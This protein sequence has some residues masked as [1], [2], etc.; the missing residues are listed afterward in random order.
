MSIFRQQHLLPGPPADDGDVIDLRHHGRALLRFRYGILGIGLLF[1]IVAALLMFRADD[2][3]RSSATLMI[4]SRQPT[5]PTIED[6][7]GLETQ[8]R[9]Y[10][11]TQ[12]E[13]LKGRN[14]AER[15]IRELGLMGKPEFALPADER[16]DLG[17]KL[18]AF[19]AE[20]SAET[21]A[22]DAPPEGE[23]IDAELDEQIR[24]GWALDE[25]GR[26]L[27]IAPVRNTDL[28]T[29]HFESVNPQLAAS[30][31]NTLADEFIESYL[32]QRLDSTRRASNWMSQ[33]LAGL[34]ATLDESEAKLQ[35][36]LEKEGLVN[37]EGVAALNIQELDELTTQHNEARRTRAEA[38]TIWNRTQ[39]LQSRDPI[40]LLR[41]PA[42][43]NHPAID[44]ITNTIDTLE[45]QSAELSQR[46]GRKHPRMLA[47]A[48]QR[49]EADR[50]LDSQLKQVLATIETDYRTAV[51]NERVTRERLEAAKS[52]FQDVNGKGYALQELQ[53]EVDTNRQLYDMFFTRM[54]EMNETDSFQAANA[55]VVD[56]AVPAL[57]PSKPRRSLVV[58]LATLGGLVLGAALALARDMLD[59]T[60]HTPADIESKLDSTTL[61]I[62]PFA[63]AN[64]S[65]Q[66]QGK[67]AYLGYLD[68]MHSSFSESFRTLRTG[69][70]LSSISRPY[71]LIGVTSSVPNEGKT[72]VSVNLASVMGQMKRTLLI[73]ADMR[74]P[75][76]AR[77][78]G[79][80]PGAPGLSDYLAGD[81]ELQQ[82]IYPF[83]QG[84][85][86][87]MPAGHVS[88]NPLEYIGSSRF[89]ELLGLLSERYDQVIIDTPPTQA[90]S[91]A[92]MIGTL[93]DAMVYVVKA[94][95]TPVNVVRS[96][97]ARLRHANCNVIGIA[98]NQVHPERETGYYY[99]GYYDT[100]GYTG[101]PDDSLPAPG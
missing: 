4:E 44:R 65:Q 1:G 30:V 16:S 96:G 84:G 18:P 94:D 74:R 66:K 49:T 62:V 24:M 99:G 58:F 93:V 70:M 40:A 26:R 60:V 34:K 61:G 83:Q 63:A 50:A 19:L 89:R 88:P 79:L 36:F 76:L 27:T 46:Y 22:A 78:L 42:I 101:K 10:Y 32:E 7:Y 25:F 73:D 13:L 82:C 72:T 75:A 39:Q 81:A 23:A 41:M 57:E 95:S 11:S 71:K 77:S 52:D 33:R 56:P 59:N 6:V 9:E 68:D 20:G 43:L 69:L 48:S 47:L 2:V 87:V 38:E 64:R 31:A 80:R 100:Y 86:D 37:I 97:L 45:Q 3:Y 5:L 67:L 35:N 12:F 29:I 14:L 51:E 90:V 53:R 92:L 15:V 17:E 85:M 54:R 8:T 28:V 21:A 98:L 55:I 91:D